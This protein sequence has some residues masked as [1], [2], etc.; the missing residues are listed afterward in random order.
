MLSIKVL[1]PN[2][3]HTQKLEQ[4]TRSA[5]RWIR[6]YDGYQLDTIHEDNMLDQVQATPALLISNRVVCE[7]RIPSINEIMGFLADG[8]QESL[9][10]ELDAAHYSSRQAAD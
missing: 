5:M 7:G 6:P 1:G 4:H 2:H 9:L 3:P 8:L 10:N